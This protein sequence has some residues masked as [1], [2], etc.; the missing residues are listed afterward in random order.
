MKLKKIMIALSLAIMTCMIATTFV[1]CLTPGDPAI[2][3]EN[4][5]EQTTI[6]DT[7]EVTTE[8]TTAEIGQ[9]TTPAQSEKIELP[10]LPPPDPNVKKVAV[11]SGAGAGEK[12]YKKMVEMTGKVN[13]K[14]I[15]LSTAGKDGIDTIQSY[16]STMKKYTTKVETI[17]L[18]TKLYE[19]L[20]LRD[21]LVNADM[22]IEVG[23]QSEFMMDTWE[24]FNLPEYLLQAYERGVVICGG[25]AGGMCWTYCAWNDFYELPASVYKFFY[26]I[27]ALHI[28]YGSHYHDNANWTKWHDALMAIKDPKYDLGVAMDNGS[29]IVIVDGEIVEY[30]KDKADAGIWIYNFDRAAGKWNCKKVPES[31]FS[32]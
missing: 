1:A 27:D 16:E 2:T 18:C 9:N 19:P 22:I 8:S 20:E 4:S 32:N 10:P 30:L 26:G 7:G 11:L 21:K 5:G 28:Y 23:G 31:Q 15:V 14:C 6:P 24:A 25:S 13:P 12:I 29:G 17:T 3:T